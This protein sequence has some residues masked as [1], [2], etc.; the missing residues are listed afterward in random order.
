MRLICCAGIE[1]PVAHFNITASKAKEVEND[2]YE[3]LV[4]EMRKPPV[5]KAEPESEE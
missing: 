2:V 3:R 4:R 1:Y 5:Q